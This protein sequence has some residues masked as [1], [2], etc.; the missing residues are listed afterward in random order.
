MRHAIAI[1]LLL[2]GPAFAD[3]P[4]ADYPDDKPCDRPFPTFEEYASRVFGMDAKEAYRMATLLRERACGDVE[5][6]LEHWQ[7]RGWT[8][9]TLLA[10][11]FNGHD[12]PTP[13]APIPLPWPGPLLGAALLALAGCK[14]WA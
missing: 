4:A 8:D 12:V 14:R 7:A 1:L 10:A 11:I 6:P 3:G 5:T 2:G 13:I 9:E